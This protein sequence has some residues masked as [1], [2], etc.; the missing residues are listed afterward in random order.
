[1]DQMAG[2]PLCFIGDFNCIW[3]EFEKEACIYRKSDS[4]DFNRF[5]LEG[6]L[7]EVTLLNF[8]FTWFGLVNKKSKLHRALLNIHWPLCSNWKLLGDNKKSSNHILIFLRLHVINWGPTPFKAFNF[9]LDN[10]DF[11]EWFDRK[12]CNASHEFQL[13]SG[14]HFYAWRQGRSWVK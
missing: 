10:E 11:K 1:M 2:E 12:L 6:S 14:V 3:N 7:W 13:P 5:I 8:N 9:W 4:T